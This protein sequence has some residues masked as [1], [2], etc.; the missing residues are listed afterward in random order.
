MFYL[1]CMRA[2]RLLAGHHAPG[3][4]ELDLIW[5]PLGISTLNAAAVWVFYVAPEPW[6]RRAGPQTMISKHRFTTKGLRDP[7]VH[8]DLFHTSTIRPPP[9][10]QNDAV[11]DFKMA[12]RSAGNVAR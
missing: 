9:P 6:V 3:F 8:A 4:T 10:D 12:R 7:R 2:A 1:G 5:K 11:E